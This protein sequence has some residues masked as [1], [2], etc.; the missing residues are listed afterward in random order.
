MTTPLRVG[1]LGAAPIAVPALIRPSRHL[2]DVAVVAI[3]A[4]DPRRAQR[5]AARHGV[6]RVHAS[7]AALVDDPEI[8][9]VYVPLPN[10]L[11]APWTIRALGAGKHVLCEKPLASNAA[12]AEQ[13]VAAARQQQRVV[14]EAMHYRYHPL[15]ARLKAIVQSGELGHIKRIE[16]EFSVPLLSPRSIQFRYDLGGG[17]TMDVGCYVIDLVR[18]LAGGEPHVVHAQARTIRPQVDRMMTARLRFDNG[19]EARIRCA[20]LSARGLRMNAT[21][22]GSDATVHVLS[23]FLPHFFHRITVRS[24]EAVRHEQIKA[25]PTYRY[26]LAAFVS[27]IHANT[28]PPNPATDA[29][30]NLRVIDAIYAAAGLRPRGDNAAAR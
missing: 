29:V 10:S 6:P 20:L 28:P 13:V 4:R 25:A 14:M 21:V 27:A 3:A 15:A 11:H 22:H 7:Y 17:A 23:P 26:Q 30:A 1:V 5:F 8:D 12:Q 16:A 2:H 19:C 24:R 18:F 9:A